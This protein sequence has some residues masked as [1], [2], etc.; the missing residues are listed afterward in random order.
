MTQLQI[1]TYVLETLLPDLVGHD[2][3]PSAFLVYLVLWRETFARDA[4]T[5]ALSLRALAERTGLSKRA[6]QYALRILERRRLVLV[7]QAAPTAVPLY[8]PQ[9]PWRRTPV[10][11]RGG[12]E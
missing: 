7:Q 4:R 6:V 10:T 2:R 11:A 8:A 1:D 9:R 5:A 3:S 12:G